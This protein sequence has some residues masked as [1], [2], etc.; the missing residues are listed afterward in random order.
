MKSKAFLLLL[1]FASLSP[2]FSQTLLGKAAGDFY[3]AFARMAIDTR[4]L[5]ALDD[6][7]P[8]ISP[9]VFETMEENLTYRVAF[10][11]FAVNQLGV[12]SGNTSSVGFAN[13]LNAITGF[14]MLIEESDELQEWTISEISNRYEHYLAASWHRVNTPLF[15]AILDAYCLYR[16]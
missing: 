2:L 3:S 13:T 7:Y 6:L 10:I 11:A 16:R 4:R 8:Y 9:H 14:I 1:F 5:G 15:M 12:I